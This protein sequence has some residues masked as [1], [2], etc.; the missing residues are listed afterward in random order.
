MMPGRASMASPDEILELAAELQ[1]ATDDFA[2]QRRK[3]R[4]LQRRKEQQKAPAR[5]EG[6]G[7]G[8]GLLRGRL[9]GGI[10]MFSWMPQ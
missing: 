7:T 2:A 1:R 9:R 10:S 4:Q 3:L 8:Y 5:L 6:Y